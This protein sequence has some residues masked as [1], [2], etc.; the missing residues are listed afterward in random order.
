[1]SSRFA[2]PHQL[3]GFLVYLSYVSGTSTL[4]VS[5]D[6]NAA[7][8]N[9]DH[10]VLINCMCTSFGFSGP[11]LFPGFSLILPIEHSLHGLVVTRHLQLR[12]QHCSVT[13]LLLFNIYTSPVAKIADSFSVSQRWYA[14]D[15]L[16]FISLS[17]FNSS[18]LNNLLTV[19]T[20][21]MR[22]SAKMEWRLIQTSLTLPF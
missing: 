10:S 12:L 20:L 4:I 22:G 9:I 19:W 21:S 15:T 18:D 16:L 8:D 1:M 17:Q 2:L 14:D 7:F 13:G 6:F 3:V 5:L 11:S